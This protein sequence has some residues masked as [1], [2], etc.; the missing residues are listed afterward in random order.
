MFTYSRKAQYHE[1]DQ[2][3][4]IHHSNYVKW[5]E[6][7]RLAF[8]DEIG[9]GYTEVEKASVISPVTG[10]GLNYKKPVSFA[11]EVEIGISVVSYNGIKLELEYKFFN[12]T[13]NE[14]CTTATS[15]HCFIKEGR[16]ISLKR[17]L[18]ELDVKIAACLKE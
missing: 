15:S 10:I 5:M 7:A 13:K 1:T 9:M 11:D 2:M 12:K 16:V 6:E 18:P 14:L 4:M 17:D 3:G 8:M